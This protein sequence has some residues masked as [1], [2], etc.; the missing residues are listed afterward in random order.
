MSLFIKCEDGYIDNIMFIVR[1]P[2]LESI[3]SCDF[4]FTM[5]LREYL[6]L[7]HCQKK[8]LI[9]LIFHQIHIKLDLLPLIGSCL[10]HCLTH[11]FFSFNR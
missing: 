4:K 5:N 2:Y 10:N 6:L 7:I 3:I 11:F 1:D 8:I 9:L